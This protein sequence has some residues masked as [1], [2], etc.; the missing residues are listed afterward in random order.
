[1]ITLVHESN[2]ELSK[3]W[4]MQLIRHSWLV[5][6]VDLHPKHLRQREKLHF[7]ALAVAVSSPTKQ[8]TE[9]AY[10]VLHVKHNYCPSMEIIPIEHRWDGLLHPHQSNTIVDIRNKDLP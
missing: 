9:G 2:M 6:V 1:M 3:Q 10:K 8:Q 7:I 4:H 5:Q